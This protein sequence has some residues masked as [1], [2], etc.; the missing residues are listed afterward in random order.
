MWLCGGGE[1]EIRDTV[2]IVV[3]RERSEGG[4]RGGGREK[5]TLETVSFEGLDV[6]EEEDDS[7]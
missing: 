5:R 6:K 3:E 1:G 4:G 2:T 7:H